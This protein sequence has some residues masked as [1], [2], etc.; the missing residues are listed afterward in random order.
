VLQVIRGR[1]S[2]ENE[3]RAPIGFPWG[4]PL[5]SPLNSKYT[6]DEIEVRDWGGTLTKLNYRVP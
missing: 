5:I 2:V 3:S 6:S 1:A 4:S